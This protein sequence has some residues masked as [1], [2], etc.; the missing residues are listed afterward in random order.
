MGYCF[1]WDD[2]TSLCVCF[3]A[4][5]YI[6]YVRGLHQ[7]LLL[8]N[9]ILA[10]F[11]L[12]AYLFGPNICDKGYV[13]L[14]VRYILV[15]FIVWVLTYQIEDMLLLLILKIVLS[16]LSYVVIMWLGNS[17]IFK[18]ALTYLRKK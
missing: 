16:V 3:S 13:T 9:P 17:V 14:F 1:C 7:R 2:T 11:C 15:I 6:L 10:L 8:G 18:E 4:L 5:W 12:T